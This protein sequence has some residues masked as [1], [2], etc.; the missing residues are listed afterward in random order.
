MEKSKGGFFLMK[1]IGLSLTLFCA[2][3]LLGGCNE[4]V[5]PLFE[6]S[7]VAGTST[8][9]VISDLHL[10]AS[11]DFAEDTTNRPYLLEFLKRAKVTSSLSELVIAGDL[12]DGWYLPFNYGPFKDYLALYQQVAKNNQDIVDAINAIIKEGRIKVVYVPGNHDVDFS[13]NIVDSIFPGIR[14]SRDADGLGAYRTGI[15]SE[16][17]IEHGHRYNAFCAPDPL[18]DADLKQGKVLF[19]PGYFF[20][21][22]AATSLL[23]GHNPRSYAFPDFGMTE[24]ELKNASAE[25]QNAHV[26]YAV[27]DG[28]TSTIGV[29]GLDFTSKIIPCGIA[30]FADYYALSDLVPLYRNGQ[31]TNTL[32]K[33]YD[34]NWDLISTINKVQDKQSFAAAVAEAAK[35]PATDAKA[36]TQYFDVDETIDV[37]VFG[38]THAP[39][40]VK[41]KAGYAGKIYA[42]SGTWIDHNIDGDNS[43]RTFVKVVSSSNSD[44]VSLYSYETDGSLTKKA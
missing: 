41:D 44:E 31:L 1:R 30:G 13:A 27:W 38:H 34:S 39:M 9:V 5:K 18:T 26:L 33:G 16:I 40:I 14:Q 10:G 35:L 24:E 4:S 37:V 11:A 32:F 3:P 29:P 22:I 36:Y 12:F 8:T 28:A 21:R 15:R 23:S 20:T 17:V 6:G 2:L 25:I 42:N 43:T 7:A 19:G